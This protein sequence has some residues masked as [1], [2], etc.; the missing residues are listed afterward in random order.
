MPWT[1]QQPS[2]RD[3]FFFYI[4]PDEVSAWWLHWQPRAKISHQ[5]HLCYLLDTYGSWVPLRSMFDWWW[6]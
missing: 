6:F 1:Q 5:Y 2:I 4:F 3:I